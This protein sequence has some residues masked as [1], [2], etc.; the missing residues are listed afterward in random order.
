MMAT[1]P[2]MPTANATRASNQY[3]ADPRIWIYCSFLFSILGLAFLDGSGIRQ[4][5]DTSPYSRV[6]S[7]PMSHDVVVHIK[8]N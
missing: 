5:E 8:L 1:N 2:F 3:L 6:S 4:G 7:R